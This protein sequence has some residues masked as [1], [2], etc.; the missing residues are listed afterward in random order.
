MMTLL[1][2]CGGGAGGGGGGSPTSTEASP[3]APA[4]SATHSDSQD[5]SA[6]SADAA[7]SSDAP[8]DTAD[9]EANE[10]EPAATARIR[11]LS[12]YASSLEHRFNDVALRVQHLFNV[13][14]QVLTTSGVDAELELAGLHAV[15]Y[16]GATST[17]A[18]L[19][20]LTDVAHPAF[21][22]VRALRERH[23]A[24]LVTLFI[25][26][27]NDGYC[28]YAWI[29]GFQTGGDLSNAL[30]SNFGYSVV[31]ADC[32]DYSLIHEIGHNLGLAHSRTEA[33]EGGTTPWAAGH[34]VPQSFVT[35][36]ATEAAFGAVRL[37]LFSSPRLDCAGQPCGVAHSNPDSGADAVRALTIT[38]P[39]VAAYR[40]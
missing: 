39:Q 21:A 32:T 20:D 36:M 29:G 19:D 25:P 6:A 33:P 7:S 13:A 18:A 34:G 28:G 31:A 37:P 10:I 17:P 24:D 5:S 8:A 38:A 1:V 3:I 35:V 26:Y 16:P 15:A 30:E 40:D 12:L 2:A 9:A 22:D 11:V 4:S 23:R 14:N 27:L